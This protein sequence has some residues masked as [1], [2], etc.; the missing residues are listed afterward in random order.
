MEPTKSD[1]V[2]PWRNRDAPALEAVRRA[3]RA[4]IP[5]NSRF[6]LYFR[7]LDTPV[8]SELYIR[9]RGRLRHRRIQPSTRVVIEAFPSS[10]NTFCRQAFLLTNPNVAP[11]DICS[12]T[13]SP[14]VVERAVAANVPCIVIA[15]D[16]RDAV[17]STVQRF[18]GIHIDSAFD[19]YDHYYGK[20]LP[21]KDEFVVAPFAAVVTDFSEVI[22]RCNDKYGARFATKV[23]AGVS[24]DMVIESIEHRARGRHGGTLNEGKISRPSSARR[25]SADFLRDITDVQRRAMDRAMRTY[26]AF[27]GEA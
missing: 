26:R 10:G 6:K 12:H 27:V 24:D 15:R 14:R 11:D 16:P 18:P 20:L 3:A 19:Y 1:V 9:G 25:P 17:S 5:R 2:E 7:M 23:E 8:L 22:A 13:H 21:I 4:A